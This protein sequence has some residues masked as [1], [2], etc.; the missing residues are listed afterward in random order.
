MSEPRAAWIRAAIERYEGPLIRYATGLTGS[1]E[2]ARDVV[3]DT[4]FKLCEVEPATVEGH[5]AAWLFR[6]CRNRA[7]DLQRKDGRARPWDPA[8]LGRPG[9]EPSPAACL[10]RRETTSALLEQ[11]QALPAGQ[12]EVVRLRFQEGLSYREIAEV[13]G[14]SVGNVGFLIH[15]AV[16]ALRA[17]LAEP[18]PRARSLP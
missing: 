15:R 1:V 12:R 14:Q 13:T 4:F 18:E 6:V 7:V 10:E 8:L 9:D 2:Q 5:L 3:Q 11:L 16:R 17:R